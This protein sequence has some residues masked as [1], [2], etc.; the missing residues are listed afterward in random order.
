MK[1]TV[2]IP[3]YNEE[4]TIQQVIKGIP[5]IIPGISKIQ[6]IVVDDGSTDQTKKLA[7]EAGAKVISHI[8]N[9]GLGIAFATG[10][11]ASL[12]NSAD[13]IVNIDA[14]GQFNPAHIPLLLAPILEGKAEFVTCSRFK[15]KRLIPKMPKIKIWGN[16]FM[17]WLVN[18]IVKG[19]YTDVSC[20]FRAYTRDV[21]LKLN[22]FGTFTYTQ[23]TFVDLA[24]KNVKIAEVAL[25][26][27]GVREFGKS[28]IASN[29]F[30]YGVRS[31]AILIKAVRDFTPFKF[32]GSLGIFTTIMGTVLA[33][34]VFVHWLQ[35]KQTYPYRSLVTLS[36]AFLIIGFM[37]FMLGFLADMIHRQRKIEEEILYLLKKERYR[38]ANS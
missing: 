17:S 22:L 4:K 30:T 13:V 16:R 1:L 14:D 9:K 32:F 23:E 36:S 10:L 8:G 7:E 20:G 29:V 18:F 38:K 12:E 11:A 37:L 24:K 6:V 31:L 2:T 21:A 3:A 15:D 25:P 26:V 19:N 5:Q 33:I 35:T 34:F 27:R 28:K